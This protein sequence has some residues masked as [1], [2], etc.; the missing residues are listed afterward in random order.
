MEF[1]PGMQDWFNILKLI[2]II[3]HIIRIKN[4]MHMIISIGA[5]KVYDKIQQLFMIHSTT[6]SSRE[7]SQQNKGHL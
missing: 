6:R 7:L 4:K 5:G 1:S 3:H 2:N